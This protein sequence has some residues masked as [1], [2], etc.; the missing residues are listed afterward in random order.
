MP[1]DSLWCEEYRP[2]TV[3]EC[4][5]PESIKAQFKEILSKGS[6]PNMLFSG[7]SGVGKTTVARALCNE[8]N[9]DYLLI[10]GS[11]DSGI[12]VLRT[13]IRQFA[14][15]RSLMETGSVQKIVILDE[16]DYLNP[17]S[18]QPAL[19]G[20]MEEFHN[21]CRFIFTC[22]FKNRIIEAL[23]SRCT[24]I[25]FTLD[26]STQIEMCKQFHRRMGNILKENGVEFESKLL[27]EVVFQHAPDWRRVLNECQR[28]SVNGQLTP[29]TASAFSGENINL[30]IKHLKEKDFKSMRTWVGQNADQDVTAIF[31]RVYDL[32]SSSAQP[33]SVPAAVLIIAEYQY[34]AAFVADREI[35][36]VACFTELMRD[37][38]WT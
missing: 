24:C 18:T 3:D 38:N 22:N 32:L 10:N 36:I 5:L 16:A 31:R 17:S 13:K 8:L 7:T 29:P 4:V 20:F 25:D 34:R 28:Y 35:N 15:T 37:V 14:S 26:K 23:H 2:K 19:R 30:L 33:Q 12:D 27:A 1:S 21:V 6:I 9:A 11:E